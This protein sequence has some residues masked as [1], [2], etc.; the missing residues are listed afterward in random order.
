MEKRSL[1]VVLAVFVVAAL[2]LAFLLGSNNAA[3]GE[4]IS[5][6][7]TLVPHSVLYFI[8]DE[9]GF[10]A[11]EKVDVEF[12]KFSSGKAALDAMLAKGADAATVAD[13]PITLAA[14]SNQEFF[15]V[16]KTGFGDDIRIVARKDSGI[17]AVSDLGGKRIGTKKGASS[18][19][20]LLKLLQKEGIPLNAVS[21]AFLEPPDLPVALARKDL[22]AI[23]IFE[24]YA[25]KA[26]KQLGDNAIVF[27][28][29]GVHGESWNL[30]VSKELA[31]KRPKTLEKFLKA[32]LKA[33]EFFEKNRQE[34]VEITKKYTGAD[35]ETVLAVLDSFDIRVRLD[36]EL[37]AQLE[38]DA[39]WAIDQKL[40]KATEVPD[41]G[42]VIEP[43]FLKELK[44]QA[45][46]LD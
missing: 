44:P 27:A 31:Q 25:A 19:L 4:K 8:A 16:A 36:K 43:S 18:E 33:E 42:R 15:V 24:P 23:S 17:N 6:A 22:D 20:F 13:F 39:S 40:V 3:G 7:A 9:K 45:V 30:A 28:P 32:L 29:K 10:F 26:R 1:A 2:G 21:F 5:L 11:E 34:S 37:K 38:Q 14:L 35:T 12:I 46:S 41:F